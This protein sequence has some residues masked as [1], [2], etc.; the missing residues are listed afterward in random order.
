MVSEKEM[1]DAA[2]NTQ[3]TA[4]VKIRKRPELPSQEEVDKHFAANHV[5]FRVWC[6]HCVM[7]RGVSSP[8]LSKEKK[9]KDA[10][11][12][13]AMDYGFLTEE[14]ESEIGKG[15]LP[16]VVIVDTETGYIYSLMW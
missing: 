6:S 14:G 7:G 8:H 1:E 2:G 4:E 15:Y 11:V 12:T 10:V 5:P 3:E 9:D 16:I 13:V